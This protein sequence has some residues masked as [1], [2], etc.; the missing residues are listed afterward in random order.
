MAPRIWSIFVAAVVMVVLP[1]VASAGVIF[2]NF[3]D[4]TGFAGTGSP[5]YGGE[6][7]AAP[8]TPRV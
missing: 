5:Q 1:I 7:T 2:D 4:R 3:N 6:V 8:G